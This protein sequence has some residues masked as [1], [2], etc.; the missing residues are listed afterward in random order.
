MRDDG[1][2]NTR[3]Y[4]A[5]YNDASAAAAANGKSLNQWIVETIREAVSN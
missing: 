2:K 3:L 5:T 1:Y 4:P